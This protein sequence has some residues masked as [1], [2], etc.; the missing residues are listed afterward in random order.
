M[1]GQDGFDI[2]RPDEP[3]AN[4]QAAGTDGR[5]QPSF[6]VSAQDDRDAGGRFLQRLEEGGLGVLVHAIGAFDDSHAG[7]ALDRHERE[8]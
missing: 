8:L 5:E 7:T 2:A 1:V 4:P 6:L 3:K